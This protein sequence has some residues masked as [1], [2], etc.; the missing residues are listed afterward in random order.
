VAG[1][2]VARGSVHMDQIPSDV[3]S[4]E[5]SFVYSDCC[6][7]NDNDNGYYDK[8]IVEITDHSMSSI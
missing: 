4:L 8:H 5:L 6:A 1:K 3:S 7:I 2:M